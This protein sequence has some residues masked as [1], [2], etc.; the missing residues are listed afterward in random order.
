MRQTQ[1][2]ELEVD[3][4][5]RISRRVYIGYVGRH[6][7]L[8]RTQQ[9]KVV[10]QPVCSTLNHPPIEGNSTTKPVSAEP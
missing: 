4:L 8:P 9:V 2:L 1:K 7:L 5:G 6:Q 10:T 3:I